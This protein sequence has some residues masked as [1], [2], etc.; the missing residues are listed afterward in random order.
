MDEKNNRRVHNKSREGS[1]K[2]RHEEE[3]E[4]LTPRFR[5]RADDYE[6]NSF[7]SQTISLITLAV[8]VIASIICGIKVFGISAPIICIV[9]FI[10]LLMGFFL[11]NSPIFV[12]IGLAAVI[13]IAGML[14]GNGDTVL[15]G[16]TI[17]MA[18]ILLVKESG[19]KNK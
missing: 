18:T 10:E 17:F 4:V 9:I 13:L 7:P 6:E 16:I 2:I 3:T 14:T 12:S 5:T 1:K 8:L 19:S 11:G 15:C